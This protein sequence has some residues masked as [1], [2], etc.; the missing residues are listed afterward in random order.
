MSKM[1]TRWLEIH[2][3]TIRLLAPDVSQEDIEFIFY[4]GYTSGFIAGQYDL[5]ESP[6]L[7]DEPAGVDE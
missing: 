4:L 2:L 5:P 1:K 3:P 7:A 6:S